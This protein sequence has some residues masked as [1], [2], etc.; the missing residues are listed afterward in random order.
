LSYLPQ[1]L[2]QQQQQKMSLY[3]LFRRLA[4]C[5]PLAAGQTAFGAQRGH[6]ETRKKEE[7]EREKQAMG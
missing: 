7:W 3:F 5:L 6:K 1:Q 2:L 4:V